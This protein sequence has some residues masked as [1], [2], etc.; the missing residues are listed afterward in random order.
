MKHTGRVSSIGWQLK[1]PF[2]L[3]LQAM[4]N[5]E[6]I[7][8]KL[9]LRCKQFPTIQI[10]GNDSKYCSRRMLVVSAHNLLNFLEY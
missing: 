2:F 9:L 5:Q 10:R 8:D 3:E 1:P 7:T 6:I 4:I